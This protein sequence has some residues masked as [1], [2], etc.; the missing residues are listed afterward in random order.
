MFSNCSYAAVHVTRHYISQN[1]SG[2]TLALLKIDMK[3]TFNDCSRSAFFSH[4]ANDFPEIS[5]WV[6][7]CYSHPAE[8][9]FGSWHILASSGVQQGD[10]LGPL[11]FSLVLMQFIDHVKLHNLVAFH[12]WYLDDGTFIGSRSSLLHL[13]KVLNIFTSHGPQ[14]GLHLNLS[15]CELFWPIL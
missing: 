9:R 1:A 3:N 5:S 4:V 2:S 7:W 15:K 10:P 12:L 13:S 11:L 8:L 6:R 14:F